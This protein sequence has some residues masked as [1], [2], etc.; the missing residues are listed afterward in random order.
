[1]TPAEYVGLLLIPFAVVSF[2]RGAFVYG[3]GGDYPLVR[4]VAI[5]AQYRGFV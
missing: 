1:M 2:T 3:G 4:Q 5:R